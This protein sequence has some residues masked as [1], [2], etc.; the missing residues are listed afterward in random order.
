MF[1]KLLDTTAIDAFAEGVL[2]D[3]RRR[4]TPTDVGRSGEAHDRKRAQ[5]DASLRRRTEQ[6]VTRERL[7]FFQK[8]RLGTRLQ[9][10]LAS[11][12]SADSP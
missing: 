9:A 2:D 5:F 6:F 11:L 12:E 8:A 10:R 1:A 4:L 3:L 7:S